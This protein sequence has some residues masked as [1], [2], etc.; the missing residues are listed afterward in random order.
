MFN[1]QGPVFGGFFSQPAEKYEMFDVP[2]FCDNPF[3]LPILISDSI[4][5]ISFIG[6]Y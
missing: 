4:F 5:V 2:L 3:V 6:M 1:Y